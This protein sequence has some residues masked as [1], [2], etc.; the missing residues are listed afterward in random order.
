M[1]QKKP[2]I[3]VISSHVVR[4]SVGNRAAG[5]A[6]EVL[7]Y[8][9]W[10]VPTVT[11]PWHPG[12][13]AAERIVPPA[14]EFASLLDNLANSPRLPEVG[15]VLSGYLGAADQVIAVAK[16]V[17]AVKAKNRPAIFTLDPVL[18][19]APEGGTGRL[20]VPKEQ[21]QEMKQLLVPRAD[22]ITPNPFEMGWLAGCNTPSNN[23]D[24]LKAAK[25]LGVKTVLATSA[26]AMMRGNIANLLLHDGKA[27]LAEHR[28]VEGPLNGVGDL[29]A[30]LML[31]NYLQGKDATRALK[32]TSASLCEVMMHAARSGNDELPLESS[33]GALIQPKMPV[34]MRALGL[35]SL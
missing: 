32:K 24:L 3:I 30:A 16:L 27:H 2:A 28:A 22:I 15:A 34:E 25:T 12:Q 8:P 6:L 4:G 17:D 14:N 35:K 5:F 33:T 29:A 13:G 19:D 1:P 20:Y 31:G 23:E 7:G 9:V 18:G 26:S 10:L 11:L 21:A